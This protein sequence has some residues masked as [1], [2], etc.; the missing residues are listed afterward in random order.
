MAPGGAERRETMTKKAMREAV[1]EMKE[2]GAEMMK[3]RGGNFSFGE[4]AGE[5][6]RE[7]IENVT[8]LDMDELSP[9]D[10]DE[11]CEAFLG[12]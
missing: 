1:K 12:Y 7:I 6:E 10:V 2:A 5:S 11:L 9:E 4:W 3:E 8:G